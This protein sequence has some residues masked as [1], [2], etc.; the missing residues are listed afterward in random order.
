MTKKFIQTENLSEFDYQYV[1]NN[2]NSDE[3]VEKIL[4]FIIEEHKK[5]LESLNISENNRGFINHFDKSK[6]NIILYQ[7][8]KEN[9]DDITIRFNLKSKN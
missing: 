1:K 9:Y 8:N 3:I 7:E 6:V 5:Y 4:P 2:I